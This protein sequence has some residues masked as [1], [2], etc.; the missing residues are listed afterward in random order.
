MATP[1]ELDSYW[2][3]QS[4][5]FAHRVQ[6]ELVKLT[7]SIE[8]EPITGTGGTMPTLT[9]E[10]RVAFVK[11]IQNPSQAAAWLPQFINAAA[12]DTTLIAAAT[13]TASIT[14][15]AQG[16]TAAA[17]GGPVTDVM[18]NNALSAAFDTFVPGI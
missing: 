7:E 10:A 1:T 12:A 18:V 11:T 3:A 14:S 5:V 4:T 16:D 6:V 2:L 13:A 8:N 17:E 9:H 15:T